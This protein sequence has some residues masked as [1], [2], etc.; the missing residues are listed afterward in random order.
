M[1]KRS[2]K[3]FIEDVLESMNKIEHFIEGLTYQKFA[4]DEMVANRCW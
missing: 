3:M 2:Y 4:E 1:K